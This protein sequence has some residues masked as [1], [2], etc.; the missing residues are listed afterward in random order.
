MNVA[1]VG[2]WRAKLDTSFTISGSVGGSSTSGGYATTEVVDQCYCA[3]D[4]GVERYSSDVVGY[5]RLTFDVD[6]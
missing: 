5:D 6:V 3:I 4:G 1:L 2:A